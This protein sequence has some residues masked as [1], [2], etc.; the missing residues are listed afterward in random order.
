[1]WCSDE[2]W[3]VLVGVWCAYDKFWLGSGEVLV[4]LWW[5]LVS[6][7]GYWWAGRILVGFWWFLVGSGGLVL[8]EPGGFLVGSGWF[9]WV[10]VGF[11]WGSSGFW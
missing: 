7:G 6:S 10:L 5:V 8:V 11:W 4:G 1:L 3:L 9:W 2:F